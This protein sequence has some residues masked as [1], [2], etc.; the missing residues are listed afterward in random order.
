MPFVRPSS[1]ENRSG[2]PSP[3]RIGALRGI[4]QSRNRGISMTRALEK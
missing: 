3:E 1:Q 2:Y 4:A